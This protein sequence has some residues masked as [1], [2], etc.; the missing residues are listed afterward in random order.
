M[1]PEDARLLATVGRELYVACAGTPLWERMRK[2]RPG[3]LVLEISGFGRGWDP[4][5][6]GRLVRIEGRAPDERYVVE[7]LHDPARRQ[8]WQFAEFIALPTTVADEW[9]VMDQMPVRTRYQSLT[10][11]LLQHSRERIEMSFEDIES[12]LARHLPPSA[13]NPRLVQWWDNDAGNEQARAW[14]NAGYE[15]ERIDIA[16]RT[17]TFRFHGRED[18]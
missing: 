9:L 7:P 8:S 18:H 17:V 3:D 1:T 12:V 14:M 5:R 4:D 6:I 15:V 13:R 11:Y 16:G 10:D 2:P